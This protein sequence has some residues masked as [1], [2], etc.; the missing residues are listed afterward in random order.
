MSQKILVPHT[1]VILHGMLHDF[2][3]YYVDG[4]V[5]KFKEECHQQM[6]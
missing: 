4:I 3:E 2:L 1:N 6:S 5:A